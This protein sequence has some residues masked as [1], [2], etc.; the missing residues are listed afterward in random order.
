MK[1][2]RWAKSGNQSRLVFV[3]ALLR[4]HHLPRTP[5]Y[6]FLEFSEFFWRLFSLSS[7][8]LKTVFECSTQRSQWDALWKRLCKDEAGQ[9]MVTAQ[10]K[11]LVCERFAFDN[12]GIRVITG[13]KISSW[14]RFAIRYLSFTESLLDFCH[15]LLRSWDFPGELGPKCVILKCQSRHSR[16]SRHSL[17][18]DECKAVL[19]HVSISDKFVGPWDLNFRFAEA[20]PCPY[21]FSLRAV[22]SEG[23]RLF[24]RAEF[25]TQTF[26]LDKKC[27]ADC[28]CGWIYFKWWQTEPRW[29]KEWGLF[30]W[31]RNASWSPQRSERAF[32]CSCFQLPRHPSFLESWVP[33][34]LG[35]F[36]GQFSRSSSAQLYFFTW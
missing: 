9:P 22:A 11:F 27:K 2:W 3:A 26:L 6:E 14:C 28:L 19:E 20:G 32:H 13:P 30:Q 8:Q 23:W 15:N 34:W 17:I 25:V 36:I 29:E 4:S 33:Q 10:G 21:F 12:A 16:H 18:W 24:L 7:Q 31:V 5:S 35:Y 1:L